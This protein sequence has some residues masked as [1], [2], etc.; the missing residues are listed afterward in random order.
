LL[1]ED[2]VGAGLKEYFSEIIYLQNIVY[3][4]FT[5]QQNLFLGKHLSIRTL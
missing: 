4:D 2:S 5:S 1:E 3:L